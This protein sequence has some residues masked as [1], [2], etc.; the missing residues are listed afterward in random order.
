VWEIGLTFGVA[1]LL[2]AGDVIVRK[3]WAS[4]LRSKFQSRLLLEF[5]SSQNELVTLRSEMARI[6]DAANSSD[7]RTAIVGHAVIGVIKEMESQLEKLNTR[8]EELYDRSSE[9][10]RYIREIR[11]ARN[12]NSLKNG[13]KTAGMAELRTLIEKISQFQKLTEKRLSDEIRFNIERARLADENLKRATDRISNLSERTNAIVQDYVVLSTSVQTPTQSILPPITDVPR[14]KQSITSLEAEATSIGSNFFA[15]QARL[16]SAANSI[17]EISCISKAETNQLPQAEQSISALEA[18]LTSIG[19]TFLSLQARLTSV[20]NSITESSRI[21]RR[22]PD[23]SQI[24][25]GSISSNDYLCCENATSETSKIS[26]TSATRPMS[27]SLP[28]LPGKPDGSSP[29]TGHN[30]SGEGPPKRAG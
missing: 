4:R 28:A 21:T 26:D 14:I 29:A 13:E 3:G 10:D 17:T 23:H 6:A 16:T 5:H 7:M 8:T 2:L 24:K 25:E 9:H 30:A 18:E 27:S 1:A 11:Q 19:S 12:E 15:L 22:Q 20:E